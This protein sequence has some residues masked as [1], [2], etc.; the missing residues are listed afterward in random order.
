MEVNH[1]NHLVAFGKSADDS[2]ELDTRLV[3]YGVLDEHITEYNAAGH[4]HT[5]GHGPSFDS[6]FT[7]M[8]EK[9]L[10]PEMYPNTTILY[11]STNSV[12]ID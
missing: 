6:E 10:K 1:I 2:E 4:I 11:D 8:P 9:E 12:Q 3:C 7:S 5:F